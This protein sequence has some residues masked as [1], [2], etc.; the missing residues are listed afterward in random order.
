MEESMRIRI[1][2]DA[3][4]AQ[5]AFQDIEKVA[6]LTADKITGSFH[7]L[8]S[9][10][11]RTIGFAGLAA[12]L[13]TALESGS[14]L[15][16]LQKAQSQIIS[17]QAKQ[18]GSLIDLKKMEL[19]G[20]AKSYEWSSK[21]LDNMATQ[22]SLSNAISKTE[23]A[24][25]QT[26][27]ITNTDL[28]KFYKDGGKYL[29]ENLTYQEN[30][31]D[32][33]QATLQ[34]AANLAEVTHQGISGSMRMLNR[35][36]ADPA[37]RMSSMSRMGVQL[38]K[39]DQ[40]RIKLAQKQ[41][42]LVAAQGALLTALD[43]TYH[44][45]ASSAASPVDLLKNDVALI[46]QSLGQGLIPIIDNLSKAVV[47]FVQALIPVLKNMGELIKETAST[48]GASLGNL[49]KDLIP[50]ISLLVK[51]LL[52]AFFSLI[53]P[54]VQM[55]DA[56]ISPLAAA[57]E[58]LVGS[59]EKMGPLSQMF[60]TLGETLAKN[61]KPAVDFITKQF[62]KMSKDKTLEKMVASLLDTF[63]ALAPILPQV[64]V[65]FA[66]L[67]IAL[68]PAFIAMLPDFVK[69]FAVF[70]K[71]LV[72]L[73][74]LLTTVIGWL[75][76][77][78]TLVTSNKGL[79]GVIGALAA[80]WFTRKLFLTPIMAAASGIGMLMGKVIN[81]GAKTKG[82][83]A[84]L[85]GGLG[86]GGLA[87]MGKARLGALESQASRLAG[88]ATQA[89][90]LHGPGS[91]Q[92]RR[93]AALAEGAGARV[94][95]L[96]N[97]QEADAI[98][99][100]G[101]KGRLK[102]IFAL[103]GGA[104]APT[105]QMDATNKN[106][107]ALIELT[108]AL[109]LGAGGTLT[110]G[111]GAGSGSGSG[112]A[113]KRTMT[114]EERLAASMKAG[115][116]DTIAAERKAI[117]AKFGA[118][119]GAHLNVFDAATQ[120]AAAMVQAEKLAAGA[121]ANA[122]TGKKL[123]RFARAGN[124]LKDDFSAF[125]GQVGG[126]AGKVGGGIGN[127]SGKIASGIGNLG[128]KFGS[129]ASSLG[130]KFGGLASGLGGK[131]SRLA[132]GL[133]GKFGNLVSGVGGKFSSLAGSLS[134]KFG[135]MAS[136]LA[137]KLGGMVGKLGGSLSGLVGRVGGLV[138]RV[139]SGLSGLTGKVSILVGKV[140]GLASRVGGGFSGLGGKLG[141][142]L[143]GKLGSLGGKLGGLF[144][145]KLGSL[146]GKLG[147][148]V[149][150]VGGGA[151]GIA[152]KVGRLGM[153]GKGLT[154]GLGSLAVGL[155]MPLLQ[156]VMPKKAANVLGGAAQGAAMGAMFGPWGAAIGGAIGLVKSLFQN[157]KPFHDFVMKIWN[158]LKE[159]GKIIWTKVQPA[160]K[161]VFEVIKKVATI[162][163]KALVA[164]FKAWFAV[165]KQVWNVLV[166]IGKFMVNG[167]IAYWKAW[168]A[169]IKAV[170]NVLVT[171]GKFI[172][173]VIV[174]YVK[175][176]WAAVMEVWHVITGV[177]NALMSGGQTVWNWLK[178]MFSWIGNTVKTIWDGLYNS[179]V[180]AANL[181]I[182]AYNNTLGSLFSA[183][184]INVKVNELTP[185]GGT[186]KKHHSGGIVQGPRG[187]EV[188][189]ILQAGEA[190][191][192]L[193]QMNANRG[194]GGGNSLAVHPG[195]VSI[196]VNGNA[197]HAT[198]AEI[199]KHVEAQFKEL[200]RTLKGMGR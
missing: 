163:V 6:Q 94:E 10:F 93:A 106:T 52:P 61:L 160:L 168:W 59:G 139:G 27:S 187:K 46:W 178:G 140:S 44:N 167:L 7:H 16:N 66:N 98:A 23:I 115:R 17:N 116:H 130:G 125:R 186:P 121:A 184:G 78:V 127:L 68:T 32:A 42:G 101:I 82:V 197:D 83:F 8:G 74:P 181:I 165:I 54:L 35:I 156:K 11:K 21:Y 129:L 145:G 153:L 123:G 151:G 179:F 18:K 99:G 159:W 194:N 119:A 170:W 150:K 47:P 34:T 183:I 25:A 41:N 134:S 192:S 154:G 56:V 193:A 49:F 177:W 188:P 39:T 24:K 196:V 86:G 36:M 126:M 118:G 190:V 33:M 81:L 111:V 91:S 14:Q 79:T 12:G 133:S 19:Q 112:S 76:K 51:G 149:S 85:K 110:A 77:L 137:G 141:G 58:K 158:T 64:A 50:F 113:A 191:T 176:W 20:D 62:D 29:K 122:T 162:Y 152:G 60:I 142:S 195:A 9:L 173:S 171:I 87:G 107:Q 84:T 120:K 189:A 131:F 1:L 180:K 13:D 63:K 90:K 144:G 103:G 128:G 161:V 88:N 30:G 166:T 48:L 43:K 26:L 22:L 105:N 89:F 3:S 45:V 157:C 104:F 31:K 65:A 40:D 4:N 73:T 70:T 67:V 5:N 199:K 147:S 164:Y 95:R 135:S 97:R 200:H 96:R 57:F 143:G 102:N 198:T 72:A 108:T 124:F 146:G 71:I 15:I 182:K 175:L 80:I 138:G 28:L 92:Y 148:L 38:S 2:G 53:T 75:T 155:A 55:A 136:G 100:G 109:K 172:G 69:A 37:K 174:G 185:T 132:G 114:T 117:I 169:V